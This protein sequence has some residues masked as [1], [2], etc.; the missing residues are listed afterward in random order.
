MKAW[1]VHR[2]GR[3][4]YALRLDDIPK[5]QPGPG[6]VLVRPRAAALNFNEI[7]GCHCRYATINPPLPYTLGMEV[8]GVVDEAGPGAESWLGRR[9]MATA[10]GAFGGYAEWVV[11]PV[12]MVFDAPASLDDHEAAAFYFPF[13]LAWLGIHERGRVQPGEWVL[14]HAAAGGV[15]SAAVQLAAAAGARVIATA[16]G[17]GKMTSCLEFGAE[18]AVD[19]RKDDFVAA[20]LD[21]TDGVGVDLVFDG[22]GGET[23]VRSLQCMARNGRLMIIGF[24][25]AIEAEDEPTVTPRALCFGNVSIGGV[26]LSYRI[27]SSQTKRATGFNVVPRS[28]GDEIQRSLEA[29]LDAGKIRPIIGRTVGFAD[30]PAALDD[31]EDRKT[32]GRTVVLL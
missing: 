17:A 4:S 28:V 12:D 16:G 30:L 20:V 3:P 8:V 13:H 5:P 7:D 23:T 2:A 18:V 14:I 21:A 27:D 25:S 19:Y 11:A 32:I 9:V 31:M 29:L 1:R 10:K 6:E 15:G 26:L 22:V 24:A